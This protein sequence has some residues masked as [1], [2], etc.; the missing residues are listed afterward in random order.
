MKRR[1]EGSGL[2]GDGAYPLDGYGGG[3]DAYNPTLGDAGV[4]DSNEKRLMKPWEYQEDAD[5]V[6]PWTFTYR[7]P[8]PLNFI[9]FSVNLEEDA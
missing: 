1:G 4:W 7:T 2:D 9:S 5:P 6:V 3:N 8:Y